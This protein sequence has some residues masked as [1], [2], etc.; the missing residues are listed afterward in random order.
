[1]L[2]APVAHPYTVALVDAEGLPSALRIAAETR[3]A[4]S[5]ERSLG[6]VEEVEAALRAWTA[7]SEADAVDLDKRTM[8]Q[9][10]R[11]PRAA[12]MAAQAGFRDLGELPGAHFDV[13]L[14]RQ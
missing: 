1:L 4:T 2:E 8:E 9:A 11:W 6:G 12:N 14:P 5:L 10:V 7:A 3:F 13:K